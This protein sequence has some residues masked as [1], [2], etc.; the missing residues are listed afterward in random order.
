MKK[1]VI[2]TVTKDVVKLE[3]YIKDNIISVKNNTYNVCVALAATKKALKDVEGEK[4]NIIDYAQKH[5]N[6]GKSQTYSF[7]KLADLLD[8]QVNELGLPYATS[9]IYG[10]SKKDFSPTALAVLVGVEEDVVYKALKDKDISFTDTVESLK[11]WKKG[12]LSIEDKA[13]E[14]ETEPETE[15]P[16]TEEPET[17]PEKMLTTSYISTFG[18]IDMTINIGL[19]AEEKAELLANIISFAK[20]VLES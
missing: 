10:T 6:I 17:E 13:E 18:Q 4:I 11:E 3:S 14:P 20:S 1:N 9:S 5:F 12:L 19:T 15:E 8:L 2:T 16:E 7:I